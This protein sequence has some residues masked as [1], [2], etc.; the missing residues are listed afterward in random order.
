MELSVVVPTLN[1][2]DSLGAT[3]DALAER[4][5]GAEVVVAN[6]PSTDG[7][8]GMVRGRDDVDVLVKVSDR[9]LNVARNAGIEA[10]TGDVVALVGH[11]LVVGEG[12]KEALR[13]ALAGDAAVTTGPARS[14]VS[15]GATAEEPERRRIAGRSVTYFEGGNVAFE[16]A[17]LDALDGFDEYLETGGARDTAHRLAALDYPVA[18]R[19]GMSARREYGTDGGRTAAEWGRKYRSLAY[20]LVKNYGV[21][22]TVVRR[23]L[24]HA[25][26]E[27]VANA[28]EVV[29]GD[30][31]PTAWLG[32]GRRVVGGIATGVSDGL[33]SRARDRTPR[34]NPHGISDRHDRAV[35]R[36]DWR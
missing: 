21:R 12:W 5:P 34:R 33:V 6:G 11:D 10:A 36:Y 25:G 19:S 20:R 27:A 9:T 4:A 26:S 18:W 17:A 1:G 15:G 16:R 35:A 32:S 30:S 22:P 3:L 29:R 8:T 7:T 14:R 24:S 28:R 31:V 13:D 2:R 23:I